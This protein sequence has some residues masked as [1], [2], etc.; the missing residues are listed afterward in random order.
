MGEWYVILNFVLSAIAALVCFSAGDRL[1]WL[2]FALLANFSLS[3]YL[4][5]Q[6]VSSWHL[7]ALVSPLDLGVALAML[8][9]MRAF[10]LSHGLFTAGFVMAMSFFSHWAVHVS[11]LFTG[12][13]YNGLYFIATNGA[14]FIAALSLIWTGLSMIR[15]RYGLD[16]RLFGPL[17]YNECWRA[18]IG[19]RKAATPKWTK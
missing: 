10:P 5:L 16:Y 3:T 4:V 12:N 19:A 18:P 15:A 7:K 1:R 9:A 6:G 13:G 8:Y 14:I 11:L 17:D 2:G